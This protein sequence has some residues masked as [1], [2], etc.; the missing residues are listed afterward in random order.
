MVNI[1]GAFCVSVSLC[2]YMALAVRC[3]LKFCNKT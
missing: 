1:L 2:V 3:I